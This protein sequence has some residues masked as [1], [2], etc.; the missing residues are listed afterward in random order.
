[1]LAKFIYGNG[2]EDVKKYN[3]AQKAL[4]KVYPGS[5]ERV[6]NVIPYKGDSSE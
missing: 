1:M 6:F 5:K 2:E 4:E 3:K